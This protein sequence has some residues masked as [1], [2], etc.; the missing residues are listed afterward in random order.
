M[1]DACF[2]TVNGVVYECAFP[3]T[4]NS[5]DSDNNLIDRR[6]S[7]VIVVEGLTY[8]SKADFDGKDMLVYTFWS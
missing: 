7:H 2:I 5:H 1:T 4:C 8:V 6:H 3:C